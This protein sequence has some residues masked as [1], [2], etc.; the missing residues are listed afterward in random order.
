MNL[1]G[2]DAVDAKRLRED[3]FRAAD[4]IQAAPPGPIVLA[5]QS[6]GAFLRAALGTIEAGR[7]LL[8]LDPSAPAREV[9]PFLEGAG[10][11]LLDTETAERWTAPEGTGVRRIA[12]A[13]R[14]SAWQR[15]LGRKRT[16]PTAFPACLAGHTPAAPA[17]P[18][19]DDVGVLLRTSGTTSRPRLVPWRHSALRAQQDTL[20]AA[21]QLGHDSRLM[22]LLPMHH[23]DGLVM[24]AMLAWRS[25]ADLI[26]VGPRVVEDLAA[27]LDAIWRD[28]ATHLIATPTLLALLLRAGE[29]LREVFS[30]RRFRMVVSTAA[31]LPDPIWQ[32]FEALTGRP[33][34]NV[35]GLTETGNLFFAGPDDDSRQKGTVGSPRDCEVALMGE[36]GA[37]TP[38]EADGEIWIRGP[39]VMQHYTDGESPLTDGWYPTGDVGRRVGGCYAIVGRVKA[40]ISVGG[41][42]VAPNEVSQTLLL[43]PGVR[44]ARVYSEPDTI[45][46]ERVVATV[47]PEEP[48]S[49]DVQALT[50]WLRDHLSEH[51][52]PRTIYMADHVSR[53]PTG[54]PVARAEG[55]AMEQVMAL[56]AR[57]FRTPA[58]QLTPSTRPGDVPGWDSLG[59]LDFV[60]ALEDVFGIRV[61]ARE[62]VRLRSLADAIG[63]VESHVGA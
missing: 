12:P 23:I 34:V 2:P 39:S 17:A 47:V 49:I 27:V 50:D 38:P 62:L 29:D 54:K 53:G 61:T 21:L 22:N 63:L 18:S 32:R 37:P 42:K 7:T 13:A 26:R 10:L 48:G 33:V 41:L 57:T 56:A 60:V 58:D 28:D 45:L 1:L 24:G 15:L 3:V 19:R 14:P 52:L 51:K 43:H 5:S 8:P 16:I 44:D 40:M 6:D 4:L 59:H 25:G 9:A 31:P 20:A 55:S 11:L 46:G 30:A 35:Y 36:D